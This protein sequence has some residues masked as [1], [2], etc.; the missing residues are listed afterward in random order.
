MLGAFAG[1][2]LGFLAW[3]FAIMVGI[4]GSLASSPILA[5]TACGAMLGL[6]SPN[7]ALFSWEFTLH[8]ISGAV[9]MCTNSEVDATVR[10]VSTGYLRVAFGMGATFV[11]ALYF[12]IG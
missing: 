2:A 12:A 10:Q 5:G 3:L 7:A 11:V 8:F 4:S 9:W 1:G 6:L